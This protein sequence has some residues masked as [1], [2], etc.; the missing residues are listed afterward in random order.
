M[1]IST[2][3]ACLFTGYRVSA[4]DTV[5]VSR[6]QFADDTLLV[7]EKICETILILFEV[8]LELKVNFHKSMLVGVMT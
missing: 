7:G 2:V 8:I 3:D 1:I 6:L 4:P 5:L